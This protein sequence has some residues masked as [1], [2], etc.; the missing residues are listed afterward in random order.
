M[1]LILPVV[2]PQLTIT[3]NQVDPLAQGR[4]FFF[5][6]KNM[7]SLTN[8]WTEI[9]T[10]L[11]IDK[12]S[13]KAGH[14]LFAALGKTD[15]HTLTRKEIPDGRRL[16]WPKSRLVASGQRFRPERL[17]QLLDLCQSFSPILHLH[18]TV[19]QQ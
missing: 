9:R 8:K 18:N 4:V 7:D 13:A 5:K 12:D 11:C 2:V 10:L 3:S 6:C 17:S 14:Y 19:D 1:D 16:A 15:G